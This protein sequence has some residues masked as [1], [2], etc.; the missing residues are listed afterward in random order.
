MALLEVVRDVGGA[1]LTVHEPDVSPDVLHV[2]HVTATAV[3][4]DRDQASGAW[5]RLFEGSLDRGAV[6]GRCGAAPGRHGPALLAT[7]VLPVRRAS[8]VTGFRV[9][10]GCSASRLLRGL[11]V[12]GVIEG[13]AV[14]GWGVQLD[15]RALG[16]QLPPART[17]ASPTPDPW[18]CS[19]NPLPTP[20]AS[21][22][23]AASSTSTTMPLDR[24][25]RHSRQAQ[26]HGAPK[27]LDICGYPR[28]VRLRPIR[29]PS[30][31]AGPEGWG[32]D[33]PGTE[34]C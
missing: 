4:V 34:G 5:S 26:P 24:H 31:E 6:S 32:S 8:A 1:V 9:A 20:T 11:G 23:S 13:E 16:A 29:P 19:P 27:R 2:E 33:S 28:Y 7:G 18:G 17:R 25:G 30:T 10:E 22:H 21:P 15:L 12:C 14:V 3:P